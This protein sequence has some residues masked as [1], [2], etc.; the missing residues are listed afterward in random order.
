M[1]SL[2]QRWD[3]TWQRLRSAATATVA[4]TPAAA[5]AAA[6]SDT[7]PDALFAELE[8]RYREP[9]RHYHTLQHLEEC[10]AALD[11]ARPDM[12]DAVAV[13]LALWFH[14]AVYDVHRHDN[15]ER[16]AALATARLTQAGVPPTRI[17]AV[18]DLILA[19]R[20][21]APAAGS[22]AAALV[23]VDLAILGAAPVRFAEYERQIR[24]EYAQVPDDVFV[25]ARR[26]ILEHFLQR[27]VL[28][29]TPALRTRHER[30]A[31]INLAAALQ[32]LARQSFP[33]ACC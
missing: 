30:Q 19:T 16:S 5:P 8:R 6:L 22:A 32:R 20:H 2:R 18:A 9:Q 17:A 31:R 24:A 33:G 1:P 21:H 10:F 4:G 13:E 29:A 25:P 14:D 12:D 7:A 3:A 23:D 26:R 15:E 11:E 28:F 27:P